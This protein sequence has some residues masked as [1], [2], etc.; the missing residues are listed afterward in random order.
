MARGCTFTEMHYM[1]RLGTS[2]VSNTVRLV[3]CKIWAI[4]HEDFKSIPTTDEWASTAIGFEQEANVSHCLGAADGKHVRFQKPEYSSSMYY[5]YKHYYSIVLLAAADS[6][7]L[8]IYV[9]VGEYGKDCDSTTLKKPHHCGNH[10][11]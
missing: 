5:N 2:T 11:S 3:C 6:N 7:Y 8:F 9:D 1:Y 10:Y 4:L